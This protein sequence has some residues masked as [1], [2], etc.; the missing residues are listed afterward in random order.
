M[1]GYGNTVD[2]QIWLV[3]KLIDATSPNP[4]GSNKVTIPEFQRRLVWNKSKQ[5]LLIDSIRK[6]YPFGSILLFEDIKKGQKRRDGKIYYNLIDGLQRT[7]ALRNYINNQ[8]GFFSKTELDDQLIEFIAQ[9]LNRKTEAGKDS[10]AQEIVKWVQKNK[11]FDARTGW[12]TEGL[13]RHLIFKILEY[14]HES[15]LFKNLYLQL[16]MDDEVT[17]RLSSFLDSVSNESRTILDAEVPVIVFTGPSSKLPKVFELLNSK[18]TVLS[19]YEIFA[20]QWIDFRQRIANPK[21]IEAIWKKYEALEEEGYT[22][23]VAEEATDDNARRSR[24]YSLFDYLFG[25]GQHLSDKY[26]RLFKPAKNDQ[27]SS[28]GFNLTTA[29]VGLHVSKMADL[30][31]R[32]QGMELT[33]LE[34]CILESTR[35]VDNILKQMISPKRSG[36][37]AA[38]IYHSELMIVSL[39]AT[40]FQV[41]FGLDDLSD[42]PNWRADR[43]RLKK[44][45]AMF[46]LHDILHDDWRGSGDNKLHDT[47]RS[48]RYLNV[49]PPSAER[50]RQVFDDWYY[51][52]QIDHVHTKETKRYIRDSRP[53]YL[54]LKYIYTQKNSDMKVYEVEHIIPV[55]ELQALMNPGE[56]RHL[57]VIGNL[58]L[59][60][61]DNTGQQTSRLCPEN[62]LPTDLNKN[63][64]E[65]FVMNRWEFLKAKF[66]EVWRDH[67]PRDPQT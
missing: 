62:L 45:L 57:N 42:N 6:G 30:P 13:I 18:G 65:D 11:G 53:E 60:A 52:N 3:G 44:N 55:K 46:Y 14:S 34:G 20:A 50:W 4:Q 31:Q 17:Y 27:P 15:I 7:Q 67:I 1:S 24:E 58:A 47:V 10:I 38:P 43:R 26:P 51:A 29:C 5:A 49:S 25:L 39:I 64:Y 66:I 36:R 59:T 48:L 2:I 56:E 41:R 54:L 23:D 22:L 19:R 12:R 37:K 63:S 21:I 8:N 32:I 40:A 35:F 28:V 9:K 61:K 16:A 33:T